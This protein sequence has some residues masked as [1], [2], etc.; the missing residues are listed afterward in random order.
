MVPMND[1]LSQI[2]D[3]SADRRELLERRLR[4]EGAGLRSAIPPRR[5]SGEVPLSFAQEQIW[6]LDQLQ[7]GNPWYNIAASVRFRGPLDPVAL[8]QALRAIVARHEILRT[9][10]V[11]RD[12]QPVQVIAP[13]V[14][15]GLRLTDLRALP[16]G[17]REDRA[18]ELTVEEAREPFDLARGPLLRVSLLRLDDDEHLL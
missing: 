10:I 14:A 17:A 7:P 9:A 11:A 13:A 3:L 8:E 5:G 4:Q 15:L 2:A 16:A 18:R 1:V 12:R 6:F